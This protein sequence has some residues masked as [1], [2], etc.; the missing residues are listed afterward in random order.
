MNSQIKEVKRPIEHTEEL[1]YKK[2]SAPINWKFILSLSIFA[3]IILLGISLY[4]LYFSEINKVAETNN[5]L[6]E[7]NVSAEV[8]PQEDNILVGIL[9]IV[10]IVMLL[11]IAITLSI[12]S[13]KSKE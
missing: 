4:L 2:E 6:A 11:A 3:P 5:N 1:A 7:E 12:M 8:K 9:I 13:R 10:S